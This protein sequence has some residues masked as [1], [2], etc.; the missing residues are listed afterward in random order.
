MKRPRRGRN[1]NNRRQLLQ[2]ARHDPDP[3]RQDAKS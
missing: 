1:R 3:S 2:G